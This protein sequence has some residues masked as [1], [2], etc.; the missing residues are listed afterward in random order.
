MFNA[1]EEI[2]TDVLVIGGGGAGCWAALR[3]GEHDLDVTLLNQYALQNG[4]GHQ[5]KEAWEILQNILYENKVVDLK[6]DAGKFFTND[7]MVPEA[8]AVFK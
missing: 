2:K 7:F 1:L 3:A 5:T 6:I 4:F 8:K